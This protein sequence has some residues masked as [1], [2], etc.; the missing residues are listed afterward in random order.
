MFGRPVRQ[1]SRQN[2]Q[3]NIRKRMEDGQPMNQQAPKIL[4]LP[5]RGSTDWV[6]R[7]LV[8]VLASKDT[9]TQDAYGR[10]LVDFTTWRAHQPGSNGLFRPATMTK[11]AVKTYFDVKKAEKAP[12]SKA[13]REGT[14]QPLPNA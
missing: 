1:M 3:Q 12:L 4:Y 8:E 13:E 6:E 14:I 11:N 2:S 9:K 5:G 7:Y 10:V